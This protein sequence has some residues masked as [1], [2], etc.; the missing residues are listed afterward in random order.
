MFPDHREAVIEKYKHEVFSFETVPDEWG[1]IT[2]LLSIYNFFFRRVVQ[3]RF[4]QDI[5]E[6]RII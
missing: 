3:R 5:L 2:K 1:D 4:Q 6:P